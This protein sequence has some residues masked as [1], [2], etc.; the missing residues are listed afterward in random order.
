MEIVNKAIAAEELA[1]K[2]TGGKFKL[3][4]LF[5]DTMEKLKKMLEEN[6]PV[7]SGEWSTAEVEMI[8]EKVCLDE[9]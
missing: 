3:S 6:I 8:N 9:C 1:V 7:A 5:L 4:A 2:K